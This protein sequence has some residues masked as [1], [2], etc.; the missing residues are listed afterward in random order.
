MHEAY[1]VLFNILIYLSR[2]RNTDDSKAQLLY[3]TAL[4]AAQN[5]A[6]DFARALEANEAAIDGRA[7]YNN[8]FVY[9]MKLSMA[10]ANSLAIINKLSK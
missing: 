4:M 3:E 9:V 10:H 2:I 5:V 8:G 7:W 6:K 1:I